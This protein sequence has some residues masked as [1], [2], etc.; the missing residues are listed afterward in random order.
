MTRADAAKLISI[1]VMAYPNFDKF[2]DENQVKATVDLW[3]MMFKDDNSQIVGLATQ[4]HIATNKFPPSVAEIRELM[5]EMQVPDLI[6]PDKA[7]LAVADYIGAH[8]EYGGRDSLHSLPPLIERVVDSIGYHNLY[9]MNC[10]SYRGGKPGMARVAFLGIYEPAYEREKKRAMTPANITLQIDGIASKT[11][12]GGVAMLD[13]VHQ[14]KVEKDEEYRRLWNNWNH[15]NLIETTNEPKQLA[16][17][18]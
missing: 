8:G 10:G 9:E 7:W 15:H 3:A 13:E 17:G 16:D 14:M 4:K 12:N 6:P 2:R 11:T 5:V 1:I 18:S